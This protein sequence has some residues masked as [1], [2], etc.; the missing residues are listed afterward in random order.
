MAPI[1]TRNSHPIPTQE[2]L[3]A[4]VKAGDMDS[5]R[6]AL[7]G[8]WR[9]VRYAST[10]EGAWLGPIRDTLHEAQ[11]DARTKQATLGPDETID[12]EQYDYLAFCIFAKD[13]GRWVRRGIYGWDPE[14]TPRRA[15]R[16]GAPYSRRTPKLR[17]GV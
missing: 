11:T 10:I 8:R 7:H 13:L 5:L 16:P 1:L 17:Q 4:W 3:D 14:V 15:R 6:Y 2:Q 9:A 12:I